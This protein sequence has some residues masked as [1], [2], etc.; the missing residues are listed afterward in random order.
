M[1]IY[2]HIYTVWEGTIIE[3]AAVSMW[4]KQNGTW[5]MNGRM[6]ETSTAMSVSRNY[7]VVLS[8][9]HCGNLLYIIRSDWELYF[10]CVVVT[11]GHSEPDTRAVASYPWGVSTS[12]W[13][14]IQREE[15]G[16][17]TR[18]VLIVLLPK[19]QKC[20]FDFFFSTFGA[21]CLLKVA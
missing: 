11:E 9:N 20:T 19:N 5:W 2:I 13:K 18:V 6:N 14:W 12:R 17:W 1:Y 7:P 4:H 15:V 21:T 8:W 16:N 3:W 10:F